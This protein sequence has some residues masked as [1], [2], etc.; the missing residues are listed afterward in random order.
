M[1]VRI[2]FQPRQTTTTPDSTPAHATTATTTTAAA[3]SD[4]TALLETTTAAEAAVH[5]T[6]K[7]T[8]DQPTIPKLL[9][10]LSPHPNG[11][12]GEV[13]KAVAKP[14]KKSE[15][16]N[17]PSPMIEFARAI[18]KIIPQKNTVDEFGNGMTDGAQSR[19]QL[20]R[21]LALEHTL[22][23]TVPTIREE[24]CPINPRYHSIE[25]QELYLVDWK[26][27]F[28]A[29]TLRC[30]NGDCSGELHAIRTNFSKRKKLFPIFKSDGPPAWCIAPL[31]SCPICNFRVKAN[32][33]RLLMSPPEYIRNEY[34]VDPKYA[35]NHSATY[36]LA[37][38]ATTLLEDLML[39]HGNGDM[40]ARIFKKQI[41]EDYLIRLRSYLSYW[42]IY[43]ESNDED[44]LVE[45]PLY[46]DKDTEFITFFPPTGAD[47]RDLF[48]DA[49]RSTHTPYGVTDVDRATREIQSVGTDKCCAVDHTMET[50]RNYR[51]SRDIKGAFAIWTCATETGEIASAV[52]VPTTKVAD[53]AHAAL[54][55][56]HR[57][58][59][60][61]KAMYSDTWPHKD[62]FWSLVFGPDIQGR[63]GLFHGIQRLVRKMRQTHIDYH[64]AVQELTACF[65]E[66]EPTTLNALL[67]ALKDGKIGGT[68][69]TDKD[70]EEMQQNND[71][72]KKY[73]QFLMKQMH[74]AQIA[75]HK[76]WAWH[77]K[78]KCSGDGALGRKDPRT[79]KTLFMMEMKTTLV[80]QVKKVRYIP[81]PMP[82]D[83]MYR[84]I[85]PP[86]GS[87]HG[88]PV[89]VSL[90]G[91]S[92]LESFHDPLSNY[93]NT[94]TRR[95]LA[96][97]LNL[98][99]TARHNVNIR[100]RL[101]L[102][103][104][105]HEERPKVIAFWANSPSYY[106]H[107][108]LG[109]INGL[110]TAAGYSTLPFKSV[111]QISDDNGERFFS[112]YFIQEKSRAKTRPTSALNDL[113]HCVECC[114]LTGGNPRNVLPV[115][116]TTVFSPTVPLRQQDSTITR[117]PANDTT[118][119]Q[120]TKTART[121][122]SSNNMPRAQSIPAVAMV[123]PKP[124]PPPQLNAQQMAAIYWQHQRQVAA[125]IHLLK[126][127]E[128]VAWQQQ[129]D[130]IQQGYQVLRVAQTTRKR[131]QVADQEICCHTHGRYLQTR[132]GKGGKPP[133]CKSC[134]EKRKKKQQS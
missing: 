120:L 76:L 34:P 54:Q 56:A 23:I 73:S 17:A 93:A 16:R 57:P 88:L 14:A 47:L 3:S 19:L 116:V 55:M 89:Y 79:D 52:M 66:W 7:C 94:A 102:T 20:L 110:A 124:I 112:E 53:C 61:P 9:A 99:G 72:W 108:M 126:Q 105:P 51:K 128:M 75:E 90:R 32:D 10:K 5:T 111:R 127:Q 38:H 104:L 59:F 117:H 123:T 74:P 58:N 49:S 103:S 77:R 114:S 45:T 62:D 81:D 122:Q 44:M 71:F 70:I 40:V 121:A 50:V 80:E 82:V 95:S 107:S 83:Q 84:R 67:T 33:A 8:N 101:A 131:R 21:Q 68:K 36:H 119:V 4:T 98:N 109:Y 11:F 96:D 129:Q 39:T 130:A 18:E 24:G 134:R 92:K 133:H 106:N 27:Q 78:Y 6:D 65:Y 35:G 26:L 22:K 69:Y 37:R 60:N 46:P 42:K 125:Q 1:R 113:C 12:L 41:D 115:S 86:P 97:A 2:F 15:V 25:G 100:H 91:E 132:G 30:C 48:D 43:R 87:M 63:L 28:P 13:C 64:R 31:C 85:E 29:L 118:T